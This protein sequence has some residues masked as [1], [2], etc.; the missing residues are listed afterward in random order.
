MS[1]IVVTGK[2]PNAGL[3]VL[4][5]AGLD[6]QAW[7]QDVAMTREELLKQVQG[8]EI[9]VTLLTEKVDS[10]LLD[11]AGSQLKAVCNVAVGYNNI[12]VAAC[13]ARGVTV[14]NTPGV[15]TD[16]TAD[17]ALALILMVTRRLAEGERVIRS[18]TP[19]QWGMHYMLGT[20]V[21]NRVLGVVGM[22][23]IG[24][25]TARRAKACGMSVIYHSRSEIDSKIASELGAKK[26]SLDELLSGSDVVSIHCPSNES[27][28]HL[29]GAPQFK[30]MKPTAFLV[31]TAR[32]PI[33]DEQALVDA[34]KAKEIAGAG[35]DVFEFE[36][37]INEGL[38]DRDD[39]V[40]IPHLGSATTETRDAMAML[41]A[42]NAVAIASGKSP[43]TPVG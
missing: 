4:R 25:A 41:A 37:K 43:L 27:T 19:W 29:I 11:A 30:K 16:A 12:D 33:V 9:L 26:V 20:G 3:E 32:G 10:E 8:A 13:K 5:Q 28:H 34:L 14:T 31:N 39:V 6:P 15:L 23:A 7:S 17:I 38:L 2:I 18:K 36:P 21:T 35:L 40:L 1:K 24:I 42:N 22:G